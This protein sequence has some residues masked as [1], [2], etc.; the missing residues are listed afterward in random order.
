M[1]LCQRGEPSARC[2]KM[3]VAGWTAERNQIALPLPGTGGAPA[4][5]HSPKLVSRRSR[6]RLLRTFDISKVA[7]WELAVFCQT[8]RPEFNKRYETRRKREKIAATRISSTMLNPCG[9]ALLLLVIRPPID[10]ALD[11]RVLEADTRSGGLGVVRPT[12]GHLKDL[13]FVVA[14]ASRR[15]ER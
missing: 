14:S 13:E 7:S 4:T 10:Q 3:P 15:S 8:P 5:A 12:D 1:F 2:A 11:G 6:V 9:R